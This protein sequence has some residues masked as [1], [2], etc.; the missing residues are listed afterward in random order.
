MRRRTTR[1][2]GRPARLAFAAILAA[3]PAALPGPASAKT[4]VFCSEGNPESLDPARVTTTTAMNATW[5]MFNT[6]V[7]F[8]PG[9]T[10][11]R[12]ALAES[13]RV[14]EDGRTYDFTL[15]E[16]VRFHEN[17]RFRP[18]RPLDADD[19]LFSFLRQWKPDHPF[20]G[21][22]GFAYFR[23][24]GLADLIEAIDAPDPRTVRFRL[25]EP[26]ATFLA[27]LAQA[28][29]SIQ[30]AEYAEALAETGAKDALAQEPIGTG[31]F[32]FAG[33]KPDITVRYRAFEPY[34]RRPEAAQPGLA[35]IDGL[36]FSITPNPAVRLAKLKAGECH[37]MAFPAPTDLARIEAD[38]NLILDAKAELNV[39]YLALNTRKPPYDDVRVRRAINLAIDRRAIVEGAY[40]VAG[41]AARGPLPPGLWAADADLPEIAYDRA[42]ALRLLAEAGH[43]EGFETDLW[44]PPVSRPYNPDGRRVADMI[45]AD[46]A[47]VGIRA[48]L[49]TE[50]WSAY[51]AA[52]YGGV[53]QAMLYGWT[54]DNGDPDNFLNVLLGCKAAAPGGANLARWC[55]P[56]YDALIQAARRTADAPARRALY[57]RGQAIMLREAPWAPLA[58]TVVH[59]A[60]RRGVGG[61]RMDPLGRHLFE[62]VVLG[63]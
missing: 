58:H 18:R 63:E 21:Q 41:L 37:V 56:E 26:D 47:R 22:G 51:R 17:A 40:G 43:P 5:Q 57:V 13:W 28:F 12:P 46:L 30:S 45:Q 10:V 25:K 32:V 42:E 34:W 50:P 4:L 15:R 2:P 55:D 19:V 44:Y 54:G 27:N 38:P 33:Y 62:G 14:S 52:L 23:D 8:A 53:P 11:I 59:M 48:R 36:V 39:S 6:L 31:P 9:S 16:G 35:P 49:V 3:V 1:R 60:L 7:E 29:A 20:H 61:F 24:L